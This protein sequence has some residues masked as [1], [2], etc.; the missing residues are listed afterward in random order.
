MKNEKKYYMGL[1][2]GSSSCGYALTD[3]NY[4]LIRLSGKDCWAS[5][6][7][8]EAQTA[9]T[10][11]GF[12]SARRR[13]VRKR[14]MN[15]W[16]Q[17]VFS[18]EISKVDKN[19]FNRLKY[20]NLDKEDKIIKIGEGC[21]NYSLFNDELKRIYTDKDYYHD[22]KT[23]YHLR[24]KLLTK[25]A[26]DIRLLYLAIHSILTHRGHFLYEGDFSFNDDKNT[27]QENLKDILNYFDPL[28][29]EIERNKILDGIDCILNGFKD[30]N[31][32]KQIKDK[33]YEKLNAKT[34]IDKAIVDTIITGKINCK[35]LFDLP[36]DAKAKLNF[37]DSNFDSTYLEVKNLL[38]DEQILV[39]DK[40]KEIYSSILLKKL[41]G[42]DTFICEAMVKRYKE[43]NSQLKM[44]KDFVKKFYPSSYSK[45]FKISK[46]YQDKKVHNYPRYIY[47]SLEYG[48][49][50]PING[51]A[52]REEFY[53]FVKDFLSA[54]PE[55]EQDR[56]E[57]DETKQYI[58]DNID[59]NNF[60][61]KIR[62]SDNSVYPYQLYI[63]EL[64]QILKT[65][66]EKFEFL[67]EVDE[68]GLSNAEKIKQIVSYKV[69]YFVGPIGESK[70][71]WAEKV[72]NVK[73]YPWTLDKVVDFEKCEDKFI[74]NQT[75]NCTYIPTENVLPKNS[76]TYSKYMVLNELNN[77]KLNGNQISVELKQSIF[78]NLFKRYKKVT[79]KK[80][81]EFLVQENVVSKELID[82]V[83]ISG[84]DKEFKG[85]FSSYVTLSNHP[86]FTDKYINDNYDIFEKII[87]YHT[88]LSSKTRVA[89]RIKRE[90]DIFNEDDIKFL[91][92]LNFSDWGRLSEKFLI[93]TYFVDKTTGERLNVLDAMWNT[94]DNLQ[95]I[96]WE[97]R[98]TLK[99]IIFA[100]KEKLE[101][102]LTYDDVEKL[103]CSPAIKRAV[104]QAIQQIN[105]I[106]SKIGKYPDKLFVEVTRHDETKGDDGRK[107]SRYKELNKKLKDKDLIKQCKELEIDCSELEKELNE[108][109]VK[110][111]LR[112]EKL[113]LY[114]L[115]LGK[116]AYTGKTIKIEELSGDRYNIEHIYPRSLI[117]DD[118]IN[119]KVLVEVSTNQSKTDIYP[120]TE[121]GDGYILK[122]KPFWQFLH[123]NGLM[124]D[125]K[126]AR[127]VRTTPL[128]SEELNEFVNRQLNATDQQSKAVIDL[129]S[130]V[131]EN[132]SSIVFSRAKYISLFRQKNNIYKSRN[133]N[134]MH[135][136]KDAYL[137]IVVGNI[138]Y[139]R[140]TKNFWKRDERTDN[141]RKISFNIEKVF[142]STV[143]DCSTGKI[144]WNGKKDEERIKQICLKNS[145]LVTVMPIEK[146]NGAFYNETVYKKENQGSK[147]KASWPLKGDKDMLADV[148]KY[149][150]YNSLNIAYF[151]V[152][153]VQDKKKIKK[154]IEGIPIIVEYQNRN[155]DNKIDKLIEFLE[156]TNGYKVKR[157]ICDKLK[158]KSTLIINGALYL[159]NGKSLDRISLQN[160]NQWYIDNKYIK[161]I[162]EIEKYIKMPK[163][164]KD[165]LQSGED[166]IIISPKSKDDS[167]E[168]RLTKQKNLKLYDLATK[169]LE[170]KIYSISSIIELTK[171]LHAYRSKFIET[172]VADQ[173]NIV[174]GLIQYVGGAVSVDLTKLGGV[175][176]QG[177]TRISKDITNL[178]ISYIIQ[179][180]TGLYS[181]EIKL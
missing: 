113:Y 33:A 12:R 151:I 22:Y 131:Y 123:K 50:L 153:E 6:I 127:L 18:R 85:S 101:R 75:N 67:N 17:E 59:N 81:K 111:N 47:Q 2:I 109:S 43:H 66:S 83:S 134:D 76:L 166:Y 133:I 179:S 181:K 140:F 41:L 106:K 28:D 103:T 32:S 120:L 174:N 108:K 84:I 71:G 19:F 78:N 74:E 20:S 159:L 39:V 3:E 54:A 163:D 180:A 176:E 110:D 132:R 126:Y 15:N 7:F 72:S 9:A 178:D 8:P 64:E 48:K 25:P 16:L 161:M 142:D 21:G 52:T 82:N 165:K 1:D 118:S 129:L 34:K 156:Q 172:N 88:I 68:S 167:N 130:K 162:K 44:F 115:Q 117:K 98:Y 10:A 90:F 125:E 177:V 95:S 175:K 24:E 40:L 31:A 36:D 69:P 158:I 121:V 5:R 149:G 152:I 150:G 35:T 63:N 29:V 37:S 114:F 13:A 79:V 49:K 116:C 160:A 61:L 77:L 99:D 27:M 171:N 112:K 145:P 46:S 70:F 139:N 137:N 93:K 91:K 23:V 128:S 164:L 45:M 42:D 155:I 86:K 97:D 168:I 89:E 107:A 119:N 14:L 38:S 60:L 154:F 124:S 147:T 122:Q 55:I 169:Q 87:K 30:H 73:L 62:S 136:A 11:R 96:L 80:L 53:K 148:K 100:Q 26:D 105:E 57:Y 65:N 144:V 138:L 143:Y 56:K 58:L 51:K 146:C 4:N 141:N 173:A 94:N 92:S 104:W 102:D 170:K 157:V 135:H